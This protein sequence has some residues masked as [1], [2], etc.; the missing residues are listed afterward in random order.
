MMTDLPGCAS[1]DAPYCG[2]RSPICLLRLIENE[3]ITA[4]RYYPANAT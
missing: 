1:I 3:S 4:G 2:A